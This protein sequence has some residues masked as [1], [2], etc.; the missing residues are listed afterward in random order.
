[1]GWGTEGQASSRKGSPSILISS[2]PLSPPLPCPPAPPP[3]PPAPQ[4]LFSPNP[5]L[6][7]ALAPVTVSSEA[8]TIEA[9]DPTAE[10]THTHPPPPRG[11]KSSVTHLWGPGC[12]TE[13]FF[14]PSYFLLEMSTPPQTPHLPRE[15]SRTHLWLC[16]LCGAPLQWGG[17]QGLVPVATR[18]PFW[19]GCRGEPWR[20][21][22]GAAQPPCPGRKLT[23]AARSP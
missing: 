15:G 22:A 7:S 8:Q 4:I 6:C 13:T 5:R 12:Q 19:W 20:D 1:M 16:L 9:D 3:P 17:G 11:Q 23:G 2:G 18:R 10:S 14:F 21:L